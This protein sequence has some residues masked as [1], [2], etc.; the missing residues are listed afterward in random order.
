ML[1]DPCNTPVIPACWSINLRSD[2]AS[3]MWR[4]FVIGRVQPA[5][6][7]TCSACCRRT[8]ILLSLLR[9][10][11]RSEASCIRSQVSGV[12][13]NAFDSLFA[14]SGLMAA[15]QFTTLLRA[16]LVTR[17]PLRL[18]SQTIL[19]AQD[20]HF[21]CCDRGGEG[22]SWA[23]PPSFH[24]LVVNRSAQGQTHQLLRSGR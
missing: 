11:A 14:I 16:C 1:V 21:V 5:W 22:F 2:E 17:E 13:P 4:R 18:P 24:L 10:A 20:T 23:W 15:L 6:I 3:A 9:A 8:L 12:L 19:K 7:C